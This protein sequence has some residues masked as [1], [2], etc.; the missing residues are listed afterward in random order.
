MDETTTYVYDDPNADD[1]DHV[2]VTLDAP[3]LAVKATLSGCVKDFDDAMLPAINEL[4]SAIGK[5]LQGQI[6]DQLRGHEED[7][8]EI[9]DVSGHTEIE[10]TGVT[11]DEDIFSIHG[12]YRADG[13]ASVALV[14]G[15]DSG[16]EWE[17]R[18][19]D[20]VNGTFAVP[21]WLEA[22]QSTGTEAGDAELTSG[23]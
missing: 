18:E 23:E 22:S 11:Y 12:T 1:F 7:G 9:G 21:F 15:N 2:R 3:S 8:S 16:T 10:I 14:S 5:E 6:A 19:A 17:D 13:S 4:K 20:G